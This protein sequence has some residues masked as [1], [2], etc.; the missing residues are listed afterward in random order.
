MLV[1]YNIVLYYACHNAPLFSKLYNNMNFLINI[2]END[3]KQ[4]FDACYVKQGNLLDKY[5][6]VARHDFV[7]LPR[8]FCILFQRLRLEYCFT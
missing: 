2:Y 1:H 7:E 3:I 5:L 8:Y 4:S 6:L